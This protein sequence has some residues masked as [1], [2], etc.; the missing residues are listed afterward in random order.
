MYIEMVLYAII[1]LIAFT[2]QGVGVG[3]LVAYK[4]TGRPFKVFLFGIIP[5]TV[6]MALVGVGGLMTANMFSVVPAVVCCIAIG[7]FTVGKIRSRKEHATSS[8]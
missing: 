1:M 2:L 8:T 3:A 4:M 5:L 6:G 7:A